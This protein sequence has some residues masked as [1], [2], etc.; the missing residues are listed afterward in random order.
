MLLF[1]LRK[2][3]MR[4]EP[5]ASRRFS[6]RHPE[7]RHGSTSGDYHALILEDMVFSSVIFLFL[8]LPLV[9]LLY[10]GVFFLPVHLGSRS[11]I[12]FRLSNLFLLLASLVFYFWG[13][14]ML[15]FLFLATTALDFGAAFLISGGVALERG[16]ERSTWQKSVLA[17][18]LV[19][20]I[21]ILVAFKYGGFLI[22]SL[23]WLLHPAHWHIT[24]YRIA[25]P[26]GISFFLFHSMSYTIDV[27]RGDAVPTRSFLDYAC[28]VLMFPQLVAGP[29]VRYSYVAK[30]LIER[31]VGLSYFA[32]GVTLFIVGLGKKVLIA[33]VVAETAEKV[34]ALPPEVLGA[35]TAWLGL[36]AFV[37]EVYFDFSGY[38][39]MAIGLGRM[40]GFELPLNFDYPYIAA[41]VR[42]FWHR[43]HI[44]LST[45]FRDYVYFP[46]GGD[47]KGPRRTAINLLLVF[48]LCGLWHGAEWTFVVWGLSTGVFLLLERNST[49]AVFLERRR[50][51]GHVYTMLVF[52]LGLV[53]FRSDS[54][55]AA[56]GMFRA[57][58]GLG[59]SHPYP[60]A[61]LLRPETILA[62][63]CGIVFSMP[64]LPKIAERLDAFLRTGSGESMRWTPAVCMLQVCGLMVILALSSVRLIAGT[65]NPFIYFRF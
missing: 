8:F 22:G 52:A 1:H 29:I 6:T 54:L 62:L 43:W 42:E 23:N 19:I 65:H 51:V 16:G 56:G 27:Y 24:P 3:L 37:L 12:W 36:L 30:T 18:S 60:L 57:L 15:V 7:G 4:S 13:E 53:V 47:R 44:S 28:Y 55:A 41:S 10:H 26:I 2:I 25:L 58:A 39:D 64:V 32:S 31:S 11:R 49:V 9:L 17:A 59:G 50:A 33:N 5:Q 61:L 46:L 14:R 34:F 63:L 20:N 21:L 48:F 45:W 38:S 40:L 35:S